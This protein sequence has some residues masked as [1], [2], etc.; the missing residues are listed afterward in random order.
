MKTLTKL[1]LADLKMLTRNRQALFWSLMF[2][3]MFTI[4]FGFF[5]G[6]ENASVGTVALVN[7]SSSDLAINL[8]KAMEGTNLFKIKKENNTNSVENEIKK[9]TIF[10]AVVIPKNF[11]SNL[12]DAPT[13]IKVI[14]DPGNAQSNQAVFAFLNQYLTGVNFQV[15]NAKPIFGLEEDSIN[16][17]SLN[18]FDFVLAGLI[19][20]ALMNSSV[21]GI[22]VSMNKYR[23]DKILKRITTTPLPTWQF[24]LAE[25]FS[26]LIVNVVQVS[27]I[28][29]VGIYFFKGHIYGDL[30]LIYLIVILGALL[31]QLIGFLVASVTKTTQAAESMATA[32]TI[33]MMFL[34]GVFFPIDS[35]PKWLF[36]I[37]QYLPLAPLL[38][39]LRGV[40][41]ENISPLDNPLNIS[42][43][44]GW[45]IITL[46]ISIWR[47]RLSEE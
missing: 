10:A 24:I 21:I 30:W 4:V 39:I 25:V 29:L 11:G 38:R 28:L 18:Y 3:L 31:F 14:D 33:P 32:I 35:L 17:N 8:E 40:A 44:I 22:A 34:A 7:Q 19:G 41:L 1:F 20:L 6:R 16:K 13:K 37:V 23:E 47:F 27:L 46:T 36:S 15:Q 43:V 2:P 45:I 5:F 9:S 12:P 42:I 26:R